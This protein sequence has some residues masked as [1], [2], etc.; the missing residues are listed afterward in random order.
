MMRNFEKY[1]RK[2]IDPLG[3]PYDYES[4]MHYHK[5]AF[6]RNGKPT[7]IPKNRSVEIGQRYNLLLLMPGRVFHGEHLPPKNQDFWG[8]PSRPPSSLRLQR[9]LRPTATHYYHYCY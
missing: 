7:I 9:P 4:V 6:S 1:P 2:I 5:L 3:M 8:Q